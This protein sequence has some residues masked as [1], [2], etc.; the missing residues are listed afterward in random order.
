MNSFQPPGTPATVLAAE[1][2]QLGLT[3]PQHHTLPRPNIPR[4]PTT[5]RV[6]RRPVARREYRIPAALM[7]M[8]EQGL[9]PSVNGTVAVAAPVP[10]PLPAALPPPPTLMPMPLTPPPATAPPT[11]LPP[12]QAP[13][14]AAANPCNARCYE[15]G[16]ATHKFY[17]CPRLDR[18]R[19]RHGAVCKPWRDA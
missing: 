10:S 1:V 15:C 8:I 13:E 16:S 9:V 14:A 18:P 11:V 7:R 17:Q 3:T 12:P 19:V 2:D 5:R 4:T 6:I